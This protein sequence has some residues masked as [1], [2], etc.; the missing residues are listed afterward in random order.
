MLRSRGGRASLEIGTHGNTGNDAAIPK[1][2][3]QIATEFDA[4]LPTWQFYKPENASTSIT[5]RG[6]DQSQHAPALSPPNM[7]TSEWVLSSVHDKHLQARNRAPRLS[8]ED[9]KFPRPIRLIHK[10]R[11]IPRPDHPEP[12]LMISQAHPRIPTTQ[13]LSL[14]RSQPPFSA[15]ELA[16]YP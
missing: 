3:P 14:F 6:P 4:A 2:P 9:P 13:T 8:C 5:R 12:Q 1:S 10:P 15:P 7:G 11:L 16:R